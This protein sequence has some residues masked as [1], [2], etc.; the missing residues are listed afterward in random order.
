M[1]DFS[2]AI[3]IDE[4]GRRFTNE[5]PFEPAMVTALQMKRGS[6][7]YYLIYSEDDIGSDLKERLSWVR[8][9]RKV[10]EVADTPEKL[11]EKLGISPQIFAQTVA[12]YNDNCRKKRDPLGKK[13]KD[14]KPLQGRLYAVY[15]MPGVWSTMGGV[16]TNRKMQV[17][18][19]D[20]TFFDNL[21]AI[22]ETA[23]GDLFT[24]YYM[25]G[26]CCKKCI[27]M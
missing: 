25:G 4:Y 1:P 20:G 5:A 14:L 24:E 12:N 26:F 2:K 22:G 8:T 6:S 10:Y 17:R 7:A 18:K 15:V 11:A 3:L 16:R 27:I 9:G 19:T 23:T 21:F 13:A